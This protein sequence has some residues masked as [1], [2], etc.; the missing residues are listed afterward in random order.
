MHI[1][2]IYRWENQKETVAYL[3]AFIT[4]WALGAL[5]AAGVSTIKTVNL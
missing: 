2:R 3:V 1:R 5:C 4:L